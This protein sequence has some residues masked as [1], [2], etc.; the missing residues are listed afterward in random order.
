MA[1]QE[2]QSTWFCVD[3]LTFFRVARCE[4]YAEISGSSIGRRVLDVACDPERFS[5]LFPADSYVG[6]DMNERYIRYARR[7]YPDTFQVMNARKLTST[8]IRSTT[9]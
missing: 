3:A 8:T 7:H 5:E 4:T 1:V 6:V 2:D 9:C